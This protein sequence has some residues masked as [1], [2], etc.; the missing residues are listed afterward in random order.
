MMNE[1]MHQVLKLRST[2]GRRPSTRISY[3]FVHLSNS[4]SQS[5]KEN[6]RKTKQ[7]SLRRLL[8]ELLSLNENKRKR[9]KKYHKNDCAARCNFCVII[10]FL[11]HWNAT[12]EHTEWNVN[13]QIVWNEK[14]TTKRERKSQQNAIASQWFIRFKWIDDCDFSSLEKLGKKSMLK[15]R[16]IHCTP[17]P[18]VQSN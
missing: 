15:I 7:I 11:S 1:V 8:L 13:R 3:F 4:Q 5:A 18:S 2:I 6:C 14:W 16:H 10:H 9:K 12:V 17:F